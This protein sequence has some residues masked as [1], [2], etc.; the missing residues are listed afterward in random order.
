[1]S[2]LIGGEDRGEGDNPETTLTP[3][4]CRQAGNPLPPAGEG[5]Y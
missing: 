4:A 3:S 1:M 2:S 5:E